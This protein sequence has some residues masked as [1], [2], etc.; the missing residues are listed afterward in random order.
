MT[1]WS[2]PPGPRTA[3]ARRSASRTELANGAPGNGQ[4]LQVSFNTASIASGQVI[5]FTHPGLH[6]LTVDVIGLGTIVG[7]GIAC[8]PDCTAQF[9]GGIITLH[10]DSPIPVLWGGDCSG[11]DVPCELDMST[12]HFVRAIF[13]GSGDPDDGQGNKR[14]RVRISLDS[15]VQGDD[16]FLFGVVESRRHRCENG[17]EVA[18]EGPGGRY[19]ATTETN[20][21]GAFAFDALE[22]RNPNHTVFVTANTERRPRCR[23][24]ESDAL[25]VPAFFIP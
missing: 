13:G 20:G 14:A 19:L 2:P 23:P 17:V 5:S 11:F 24:G 1:M 10:A 6:T 12:S 21:H 4:F 25:A 16:L 3:T 15:S 7:P 8:P 22:I 18:L 9:G